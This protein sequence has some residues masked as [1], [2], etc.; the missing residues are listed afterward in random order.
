MAERRRPV[1]DPA[2]AEYKQI[3]QSVLNNRPSGMRQRL[4][5]ELDKNRSFISQISNPAY[6]VPIP[7]QHVERIFEICHF[8]AAERARFLDAYARGHPRRMERLARPLPERT[9]QLE[10]PDLGDAE[11]NRELDLVLR[12]LVRRVAHLVRE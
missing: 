10:V 3:L 12:D 9:L 1:F 5:Q 11:R 2:V 7:V 4:A 8:S 6:Q